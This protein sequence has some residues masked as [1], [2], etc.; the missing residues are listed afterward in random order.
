MSGLGFHS[1][2]K[3]KSKQK[4][5]GTPGSLPHKVIKLLPATFIGGKMCRVGKKKKSLQCQ[6]ALQ[7]YDQTPHSTLYDEVHLS[8]SFITKHKTFTQLFCATNLVEKRCQCEKLIT[9]PSHLC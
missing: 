3:W 1:G 8:T 6:Y 5:L 9:K 4:S 2:R 7:L